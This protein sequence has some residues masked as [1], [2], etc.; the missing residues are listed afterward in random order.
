MI[1]LFSRIGNIKPSMLT[2]KILKWDWKHKGRTWSWY[3]RSLLKDTAQD[4]D[5]DFDNFIFD[6]SSVLQTVEKYLM[7]HEIVKWKRELQSQ[8]KLRYY[9][10]FKQEFLAEDYVKL[11][12]SKSSRSFIAQIRSGVLPL[13]IEIGRFSNIP[14]NQRTCDNCKDT[15]ED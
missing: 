10:T 9:K 1:K 14:A 11:C 12:T 13:K 15:V 3:L 2:N 5:I 7:D 8:S 4:V 6:T